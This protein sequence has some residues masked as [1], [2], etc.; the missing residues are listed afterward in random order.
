MTYIAAFRCK[1]GIVL[2]ADTQETVEDEKQYCEKLLIAEDRQCPV[3][4]GGAGLGEAT[5]AFSAEV[6][7][8][9]SRQRPSTAKE[10]AQLIK[11]S[12]EDVIAND[13]P[14]SAWAKQYRT[15]Q[16]VVAAKPTNEDFVI[17]KV[18][19]RRVRRVNE[20][21]II[22]YATSL[23]QA[24]LDRHHRPDLPMQQAV[25]LAVYLLSLSKTL[26]AFGQTRIAVVVQ[27]GAWFD[28]PQYIANSEQ[29][30]AQF[31]SVADELFLKS[32]DVGISPTQFRTELEVLT[33]RIAALRDE[34]IRYSAARLLD[35]TFNDPNYR[36]DPYPKV[37][38]G[39][40]TTLGLTGVQV[41]EETEEDREERR[42]I[43]EGL[44]EECDALAMAEFN[45]SIAGRKILYL[46]E[47]RVQV[48]G[49]S[50]PVPDEDVS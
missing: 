5:E 18:V 8:R 41:R 17:F 50:G 38:P 35:R 2:C 31:L 44:R 29:R 32:V 4:I 47:E 23:N 20:P 1:T 30:I 37:F 40:I 42:K 11:E 43:F 7:E 21:V 15:A 26:N 27:N 6:I 13:V 39:A 28:D 14:I 9:A 12:I 36:G 49:M 10:L 45:S 3:A 19:G 46:G 48:R 24:L 22:G 33:E 16:Y 34:Y 25:M